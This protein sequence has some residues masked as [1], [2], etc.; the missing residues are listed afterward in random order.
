MIDLDTPLDDLV[1]AVGGDD[2]QSQNSDQSS[3]AD[4]TKMAEEVWNLM[5]PKVPKIV[6]VIVT[7]AMD[8]K[9]D[10]K[11]GEW[12]VEKL[13]DAIFG[14]LEKEGVKAVQDYETWKETKRL[15][16]SRLLPLAKK[17]F[18]EEQEAKFWTKKR[19][20]Y[21]CYSAV[22]IMGGLITDM[23]EWLREEGI[24]PESSSGSDYES[25]VPSH[26]A[27]KL[28]EPQDM[29]PKQKP[30]SQRRLVFEPTPVPL[31]TLVPGTRLVPNQ[32]AVSTQ[33]PVPDSELIPKRKSS[34]LFSPLEQGWKRAPKT[35]SE[36]SVQSPS[37]RQFRQQWA[38]TQSQR[39][40][41]K[42]EQMAA[43]KKVLMWDTGS[44][45]PE[46]ERRLK[47]NRW[48][49]AFSIETSGT[50]SDEVDEPMSTQEFVNKRNEIRK[51]KKPVPPSHE[52]LMLMSERPAK[53]HKSKAGPELKKKKADRNVSGDDDATSF[54]TARD[55]SLGKR[56][57]SG[58][59]SV[60]EER[61][62]SYTEIRSLSKM[63][64]AFDGSDDVE[65]AKWLRLFEGRLPKRANDYSKVSLLSLCL[66]LNAKDWFD[67]MLD[68]D[69]Q[70]GEEATFEE[71]KLRMIRQYTMAAHKRLNKALRFR[72][73]ILSAAEYV[74]QK[75]DLLH[76]VNQ[77]FSTEEILDSLIENVNPKYRDQIDSMK[78]F[79][80]SLPE[81][82]MIG[83]F[84][85]ALEDA[86]TRYNEK[87]NGRN[88]FFEEL[89]MLAVE[90]SKP[91]DKL[92]TQVSQLAVSQKPVLAD[93]SQDWSPSTRI[94]TPA[95]YQ[96]Q[97]GI[98]WQ[99][100]DPKHMIRDCPRRPRRTQFYQNSRRTGS[101]NSF[102][103]HRRRDEF[104]SP[105]VFRSSASDLPQQLGS[106]QLRSPVPFHPSTG[107]QSSQPTAGEAEQ[108]KNAAEQYQKL[109]EAIDL[110]TAA[111]KAGHLNALPPQ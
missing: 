58:S 90:Q 7:V 86:T 63:I 65:V 95:P 18:K 13:H 77:K 23:V 97:P 99:C 24:K 108:Q 54:F 41:L 88:P 51:K 78:Q 82:K 30:V 85:T 46:K 21:S 28:T 9:R 69:M 93:Q 84:Q 73:G 33:K 14:Y 10:E 20:E 106:P 92:V 35:L 31:Q 34:P 72:Q 52:D 83:E 75:T 37:L 6:D 101:E 105:Q 76:A 96:G 47:T 64:K 91:I 29:M 81:T 2:A 100:G 25:V 4:P 12:S 98:C 50:S 45:K 40:D 22:N 60:G 39:E 70:R 62:L 49:D 110:V 19:H 16:T 8:P 79:L 36:F 38:A 53:K 104:R 48:G 68:N 89:C 74:R 17:Q 1:G 43:T 61:E 71:W 67:S 32:P 15:L 94:R 59:S 55:K 103:Q 107:H 5:Q 27:G 11:E 66:T 3:V 57:S 56:S 80:H 44:S 111:R 109:L 42:K 87:I 102:S 26:A